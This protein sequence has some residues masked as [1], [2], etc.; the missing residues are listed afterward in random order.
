[1]TEDSVSPDIE[2]VRDSLEFYDGNQEKYKKKLD[3]IT[4][5]RFKE[6]SM[7]SEHNV[8]YLY[9]NNK[10]RKSTRLNSSHVS[11]SRMPSSA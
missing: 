9:N 10:D 11:E 2:L 3:D 4:Y 8:L 5:I 1:M 6:T 7:E